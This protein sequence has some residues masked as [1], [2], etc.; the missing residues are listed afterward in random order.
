MAVEWSWDGHGVVW[1][2][3]GCSF[4]S[5]GHSLCGW[6]TVCWVGGVVVGRRKQ[7][8]RE[9]GA[10]VAP[11]PLSP[12]RQRQDKRKQQ[13]GSAAHAACSCIK[14]LLFYYQTATTKTPTLYTRHANP[15]QPFEHPNL[16]KLANTG[17]HRASKHPPHQ[18][19]SELTPRCMPRCGRRCCH[20]KYRHNCKY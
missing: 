5:C 18:S 2:R 16:R 7:P 6:S 12:Q 1:R 3:W 17:A 8:R 11:M 4:S 15:C 19:Y 10:R 9:F 20:C 13:T 14:R